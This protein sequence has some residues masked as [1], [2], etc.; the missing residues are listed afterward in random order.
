MGQQKPLSE[1][2]DKTEGSAVPNI[3]K[4]PGWAKIL[5][6]HRLLSMAKK[7]LGVRAASS[8]PLSPTVASL[9]LGGKKPI[10]TPK[11]P[12]KAVLSVYW[13]IELTAWGY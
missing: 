3:M 5:D 7:V 12:R 6:L 1:P 10:S 4:R 8:I 9:V 2:G 11:S 13:K